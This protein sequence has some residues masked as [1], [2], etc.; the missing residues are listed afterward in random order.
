MKR[1]FPDSETAHPQI[2]ISRGR[3]GAKATR[4]TKL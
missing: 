2:D 3:S 4:P 1:D